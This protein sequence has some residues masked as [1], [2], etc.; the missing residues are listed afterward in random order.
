[1]VS[2]IAEINDAT[3]IGSLLCGVAAPEFAAGF[4]PAEAALG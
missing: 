3:A 2:V 4:V 1:L